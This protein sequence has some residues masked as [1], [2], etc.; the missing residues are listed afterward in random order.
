MNE[1][2]PSFSAPLLAAL[3]QRLHGDTL[4]PTDAGYALARRVWN[5]AIDRHPGA[6]VVCADA[7]DV[8]LAL[9]IAAEHRVEVTVRGGGH[10][11]AGR[12]IADGALLLDLSRMRN[13]TVN[14]AARIATVQGG[15]QWHDV[16]V[17]TARQSMATTGGLISSTG[18]GGFTLGGGSG[19]LMR[20]HGLA[21]DNL[22]AV[23]IV[24]A[25]GR[26]VRASA[27]DH[28]ELFWGIRGGGGGLGV[29]TSFEFQLHPLRQVLAGVVIRPLTEAA[30]ALRTFRDY[31]AQAAD[32]FCGMVIIAHAPS[33][34]F[35]DAAWHGQPVVVTAV[36]WCGDIATG[37]QAL[38]PLREFGS[39]LAD[40]VGPMPYVQWQHLQD[41]GA[42]P[43]RY[44]YWK[45]ASYVALS[46]ATINVLCAHGERLPSRQSE[47]HVQHMGGAVARIAAD[48]TAFAQ[49]D[50]QFF[51]NLLGIAAWADEFPRLRANVR[52]LHEQIAPL[53]VP[54]ML[55]NFSGQDD[56][57]PVGSFDTSHATRLA[58]LRRRYDS[59]SIFV[60]G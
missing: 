13:V 39:P 51:V 47:I 40:H 8:A 55:P 38:T 18:V 16:D 28:P 26:A 57:D 9:Q 3:R 36:C 20:R 54:G 49:R 46:D 32:S 11:V 17:A 41:P 33:L 30:T 42:P 43:G 14:A 50:T 29:V 59:S 1:R 60:R 4:L 25:D 52:E 44:Y 34:P 56:G 53:A 5:A 6:I 35:L 15:A 19:W 22:L 12:S 48:D 45:T 37:Q 21:I 31:A 7:E 27:E 24:L 10:N 23:G 2:L 58:A